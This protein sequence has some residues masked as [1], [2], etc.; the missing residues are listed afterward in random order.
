MVSFQQIEKFKP[1]LSQIVYQVLFAGMYILS[2]IALIDGMNN[3]VFV[4]YRQVIATLAIA[5]F[6]F[7]LERKD[8]PPL[9]WPIFFQIFLL[10]TG[11]A[12]TQNCY[13]PGLYY[14]SS[15]FGSAAYNLIP[16]FTFPI[17][18]FLRLEKINIRSLRGQVKIAGALICVG[19]AMVMTLYK[20]PALKFLS[21]GAKSDQNTYNSKHNF[22]LGS[23]L[24]FVSVAVWSSCIVFQAPILKRYP[25][26][27]SLTAL[28][29]FIAT[30][31]SALIAVICEYKKSNLW[32][33][34]WN[35]ELVSLVYSGTMCFALGMFLQAWCIRK[36]GPIFVAIFSPLCTIVTGILEVI[37]LHVYLRVGSVVGAFFIV[38]GLYSTLWGKATDLQ[39]EDADEPEKNIEKNIVRKEVRESDSAI[40]V[41]LNGVT[42]EMRNPTKEDAII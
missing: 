11:I 24:V 33:L 25:A 12:I 26:Q 3:F 13:I 17:A 5:P 31:E 18:I 7:L 14:T 19:G 2:R 23:I 1:H 34:G 30:V 37:T 35:I 36:K 22:M 32:T 27:L 39:T 42:V 38:V 20:G 40:I 4:T 9:T 15:T 29:S 8:R 16:V 41:Q 21:P 10:G 6:A 28:T